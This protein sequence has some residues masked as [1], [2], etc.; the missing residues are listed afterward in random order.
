[1][2]LLEWKEDWK[3]HEACGWKQSSSP[4]QNLIFCW[5]L[6]VCRVKL[7]FNFS[8]IS[9]SC[10]SCFPD[11]HSRFYETFKKSFTTF[12]MIIKYILCLPPLRNPSYTRDT[13]QNRWWHRDWLIQ[14]V[15]VEKKTHKVSYFGTFHT[16]ILVLLMTG[17]WQP[18]FEILHM[19][20]VR[21]WQKSD[22]RY[23]NFIKGVKSE[24]W[25]GNE[26]CENGKKKKIKINHSFF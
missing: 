20:R 21:I 10:V 13:E 15:Y 7:I 26:N 16:Y 3:A 9:S 8:K 25:R 24:N 11:V 12:F 2:I 22:I 19:R 14:N 18:K 5:S 23:S 6:T 1:M 17:K 4:P